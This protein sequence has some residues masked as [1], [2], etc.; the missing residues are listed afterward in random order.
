MQ[1]IFL[2]F[3]TRLFEPIVDAREFHHIDTNM[4]QHLLRANLYSVI[5]SLTFLKNFKFDFRISEFNGKKNWSWKTALVDDGVNFLKCIHFWAEN[6]FSHFGRGQFWPTLV[7]MHRTEI[8][9]IESSKSRSEFWVREGKNKSMW[10]KKCFKL[11]PLYLCEIGLPW[12]AMIQFHRHIVAVFAAQNYLTNDFF[13]Y[14][15][16]GLKYKRKTLAA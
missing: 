9:Q 11:I 2:E 16:S 7:E 8:G 4:R 13:P 3:C 5:S 1:G 15:V 14:N 6:G 12:W 10:E